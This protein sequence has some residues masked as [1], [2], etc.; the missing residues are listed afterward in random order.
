[1]CQK[2]RSLLRAECFSPAGL[3]APQ[4][5]ALTSRCTESPRVILDI[6]PLTTTMAEEMHINPQRAKQLTENIA[7]ITSRITAASK[8]GQNVRQY[9]NP[10]FPP[11]S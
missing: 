9:P 6:S 1:M 4:K 11:R 8:S 10:N 7:R 5:V 2:F 3:T